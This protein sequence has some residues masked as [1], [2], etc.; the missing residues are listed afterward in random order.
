MQSPSGNYLTEVNS[1]P[2]FQALQTVSQ[3][4]IADQII[5]YIAQKYRK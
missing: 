5:A 3:I 4:N 1:Q 2:G